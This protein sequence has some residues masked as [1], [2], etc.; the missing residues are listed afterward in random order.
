MKYNPK[1]TAFGRHET[2]SLR[3]S[4]LTKA[5]QELLEHPDVFESDESTV[6]LGVG[7]NMVNAIR[8][9]AL[10]AGVIEKGEQ[11]YQ[12][13]DFGRFIFDETTGCD[14]YLEDESTIWLL[15]WK[16]ASN[17]DLATSV[18]WFFNLFH[19]PEFTAQEAVDALELF[20][21][22]NVNGRSSK[23]TLKNDISVVLKMYTESVANSKQLDEVL[24]TPLSVLQLVTPL[25]S[26]K[27]YVTS[28]G[29][30]EHLPTEVLGYA[31]A[32]L[33]EETGNTSIAIEDLMYGRNGY[34]APGAIFGLTETALL[35]KLDKLI[36][37]SSDQYKLT[38][39]AGVNQLYKLPNT[40]VEP[41]SF[42]KQ[43]YSIS[44]K[45]EVVA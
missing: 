15:H 36:Q 1:K 23:N 16:I 20:A 18:Y 13:T 25:L 27:R 10:A 30:Q 8:Y 44:I 12:V 38:D 31:I 22:E 32:A 4:W 17:P 42:L 6:R 26:S 29:D 37:I 19:K 41:M 43:Y 5:Y 33:F 7:K 28:V 35:A 3:Y 34:A 11:H 39:T 9:W 21:K 2:F 24:D 40:Q 45:N 14:P